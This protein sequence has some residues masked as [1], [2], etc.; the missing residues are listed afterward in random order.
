MESK[1]QW[2]FTKELLENTPSRKCGIDAEKELSYRQ[3]AANFIQDMGQSL[4]V[5]QLCINTA[6]VYMHRFYVFHSFRV[7][8]RNAIAIAAV[9]LAAKVE[10]QP[11]KLEHVIKV[12]HFCL[13][14]SR[15]DTKSSLYL[16]QAHELVV[17]ENMLLKTLGFDVAIDH[18]HTHVLRCCDLVNASKDVARASYCLAS[19]SLH[20]T[21]MC[22][23]YT[24]C[25]CL[26]LYSSGMQMVKLENSQVERGKRMVLVY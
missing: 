21:T 9:F 20:L 18:P 2:C 26:L 4:L 13:H 25:C 11:R 22:L 6:I 19:N 12:A 5:S 7:F 17:N 14:R 15:L 10:E 23:Q 24:Y 3:Q 1:R 8:H 16:K